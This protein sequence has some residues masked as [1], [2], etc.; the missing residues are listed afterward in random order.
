MSKTYIALKVFI[1]YETNGVEDFEGAK[2]EATNIVADLKYLAEDMTRH[3]GLAA[4]LKVDHDS[5]G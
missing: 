2:N 3:V 5:N 1:Q 4:T